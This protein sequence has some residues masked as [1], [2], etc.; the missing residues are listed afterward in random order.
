[1]TMCTSKKCSKYIVT[2]VLMVI[3]DCGRI[4][5]N[6]YVLLKIFS[7]TNRLHTY[8]HAY[9]HAYAILYVNQHFSV[10]LRMQERS[11]S[12]NM[13][14]LLLYCL[15]FWPSMLDFIVRGTAIEMPVMVVT[16]H[17]SGKLYKGYSRPVWLLWGTFKKQSQEVT[18]SLI[19]KLTQ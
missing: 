13:I 19:G 2:I 3:S 18:T 16:S 10:N 4:L 1:M 11:Y 8:I 6:L 14:C 7:S 12:W 15:N 5:R 9:I 17:G